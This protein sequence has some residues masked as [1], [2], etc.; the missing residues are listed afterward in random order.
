MEKNIQQMVDQYQLNFKKEIKRPFDE[1]GYRVVN[2]AGEDCTSDLFRFIFDYDNIQLKKEDFQKR[3]RVKHAWALHELCVAQRANGQQCTRRMRDL[4][5]TVD[6]F[7]GTHC[8]G[9]P[10]GLYG[11]AVAAGAGAGG[12][13]TGGT[14]SASASTRC[15]ENGTM[16][17]DSMLIPIPLAVAPPQKRLEVWVQEI[18]GINYYIDEHHNVYKP[19]DIIANRQAPHIIAKWAFNGQ[20]GYCIPSYN[21]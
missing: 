18:K 14:S 16:Q 2:P 11:P 20:G 10:H 13:G 17:N 15:D 3:K 7:C 12:A 21:I 8:K 9:Q 6:Q 1:L 5:A 19:D 4:N